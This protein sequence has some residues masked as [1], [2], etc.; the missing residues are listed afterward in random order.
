MGAT[1]P[2]HR[3]TEFR[4]QDSE[5]R[6][7]RISRAGLNGTNPGTPTRQ[8]RAQVTCCASSVGCMRLFGS[9]ELGMNL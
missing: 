9:E 6:A 3:E 7:P 8:T 5:G 1:F 4:I 2:G